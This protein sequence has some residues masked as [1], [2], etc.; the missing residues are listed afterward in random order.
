MIQLKTP[1]GSLSPIEEI[2][3]DARQGRMSILVD[4]EDRENEGDLYIPAKWADAQAVNFMAT[5]GRGLICLAMSRERTE[6]LKLPLM[7]RGNESRQGTAF[8]VSIEAREGVTTGISAAD[9]ARTIEAATTDGARSEDIVSPGHVFPLVARDGGV[10]VRSGHTEAAVDIS[11]MSGQGD[12]GVI[13]EIMNPDGTMARLPQLLDFAKQQGLKV[14]SIADL[15]TY[16]RKRE[17]LIVRV[18]EEQIESRHGGEFTA[19][20]FRNILDDVEHVALVKGDVGDGAPVLVRVHAVNL[21][22][23]IVGD[24][25][26]S[27][28]N[29]VFSAMEHIREAGRGVIVLMRETLRNSPS[30]VLAAR[31]LRR[32]PSGSN[33]RDFGTGAQILQDLGVRDMILL[34]SSEHPLVALRGY[35]LS[36]LERRTM[37]Q[38]LSRL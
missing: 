16:R 30:A 31:H 19:V 23:D 37:K 11:R 13:C 17:K 36:I 5:H 29:A 3:E 2:I 27:H 28:G 33:I 8:T 10:L 9:R 22:D 7:A 25:F 34:N 20:V 15:I 21:F 6:A 18:A 38:P 24:R 14:A 32:D 35:G 1:I 12:A 4:D 26:Y